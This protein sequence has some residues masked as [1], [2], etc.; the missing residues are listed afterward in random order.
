[1][2]TG[3]ATVTPPD[4]AARFTA[5]LIASI[6]LT[7]AAFLMVNYGVNLVISLFGRDAVKEHVATAFK[8]GDLGLLESRAL[9]SDM[10]V[11]QTND[12]LIFDMAAREATEL[13]L[14]LFAASATSQFEANGAE[15]C[16]QLRNWAL[17]DPTTPSK[18]GIY[19]RYIHGY[20]IVAVALL[21]VFSVVDAR[22]VM[23]L[24][25]YSIFIAL[26][27]INGLALYRRIKASDRSRQSLGDVVAASNEMAYIGIG[28]SLLLVFGL[29]YFGQ[30]ISHAPALVTLGVFLILWSRR[31]LRGELD[32]YRMT[33]MVIVFSLFTASFEFLTGYIPVACVLLC[34]LVGISDRKTRFGAPL[35]LFGRLVA[36][37]FAFVATLLV[38]F[39]LH[40]LFT[41]LFVGDLKVLVGFFAQLA[42]RMSQSRISKASLATDDPGI[43]GLSLGEVIERLLHQIPHI[44][45]PD[46]F[47]GFATLLIAF[48]IVLIG[49]GEI[50]LSNSDRDA[51]WRT[52]VIAAAL[53]PLA[54][55]ILAFKNHTYVHARFM[56][57]IL[58]SVYLTATVMSF[59]FYVV[60]RAAVSQSREAQVTGR[61]LTS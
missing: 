44:G 21:S 39:L 23:K 53:I 36:V 59:W 60:R 1:M 45:V 4:S 34:L 37:E 9:D 17:E 33:R 13:P 15:R 50:W 14:Y 54:M 47:T 35:P 29:P 40:L 6:F 25:S 24:C 49:F 48:G 7:T 57:R 8:N 20:R 61:V 32:L 31:D 58:V 2:K 19:Y 5:L 56:V 30:S 16:E 41:T 26:C 51:K 11:H 46:E 22:L 12:C 52:L 27:L 28:L 18:E 3:L 42:F 55:W 10:G 38:A 43:P